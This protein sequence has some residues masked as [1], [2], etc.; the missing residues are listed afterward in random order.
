MYVSL[1]LYTYILTGRADEDVAAI[2]TCSVDP[3]RVL[4]RVRRA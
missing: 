1:A 3:N 2:A 4:A